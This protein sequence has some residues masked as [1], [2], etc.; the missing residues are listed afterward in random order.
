MPQKI[1]R[2]S[3]HRDARQRDL[4]NSHSSYEMNGVWFREE[5]RDNKNK[6]KCFTRGSSEFP[7]DG[8]LMVAAV[9]S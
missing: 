9:L 8:G 6:D 1:K 7:V 5:K 2:V 3:D 4:H